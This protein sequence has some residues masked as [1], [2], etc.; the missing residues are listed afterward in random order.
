MPLGPVEI[1]V[2]AFPENRFSGLIVPEVRKLVD[3]GTVSIIDGVFAMKDAAGAVTLVEFGQLGGS[4]DASALSA[5]M[6]RVE[7]IIS[8]ED[9]DALTSGL[10]PNSSAAI[11]AFEHTWMTPLRDAVVTSGGVLLDSVRIPGA[12]VEEILATVPDED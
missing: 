10:E 2:I 7:G 1:V 12:V 3:A 11:M 8:D 9:V 5:V 6:D 4:D